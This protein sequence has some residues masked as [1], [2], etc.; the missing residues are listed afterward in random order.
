MAEVAQNVIKY[1]RLSLLTPEE[2]KQVE[3][4]NEKDKMMPV[5]RDLIQLKTTDLASLTQLDI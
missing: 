3:Q 5:S 2:L 1:V 4:D